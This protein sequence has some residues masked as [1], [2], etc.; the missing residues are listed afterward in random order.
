MKR[1][2]IIG[3]LL[4]VAVAAVGQGV[5][6]GV[7]SDA[8]GAMPLEFVNIGVVGSAKGTATDPSGR[9][10]LTLTTS[11]S[12]TLRFSFTGYETA[13]HR[14]SVRGGRRLRLNV[15]L[16][17]SATQL[18][19]V[20]VSDET[21]RQ[22]AFTHIETEKLDGTVGPT[23]GVEAVIK[24]LP[25][26]HS[27]NELSSQYSVRGGSFDE[28]LVYI[29]GVEIFR[30]MLIRSGQQEGM[31][32]INPDM[33]DYILFSPGGFDA[34][35]GDKLSSVLDITYLRP[36]EFRGK[37]SASLLGANATVQGRA[38]ERM[39]YAV[40]FR[41]HSNQYVL[42]SLDT[43]GSYTTSYTDLQ[44]LLGYHVNDKLDLG[45][46]AV[47]T[48]NVYGLV[49]ESQTT[50]FGGF[51]MPMVLNV[52]FDGQEQDRYNTLLGALS[53]DWRPSEDWR[54]K[55]H[56]SVQHINESERYDVQSQYWLYQLAM[57][58]TAGDTTM[59][60][61]GVGTFLEHARNR[62]TTNIATLSLNANRYAR[63]GCWDMGL[64]LQVEDIGDHLREWKWVDSAGYALPTHIL[65]FGDSSNYPVNPILQLYANSNS[66]MRT[67]RT[68]AYLQR[69]LNFHTTSGADIKLL[70]GLRGQIYH[71]R[72][73]SNGLQSDLG[74]RWM[75]SPRA[76]V[77]LK[78]A[79]KHDL[80][81]RLA[82][83]IYSQAPFYREYRRE[84]GTLL[85]DVRPQHSYQVTGTADWNFR[86]WNKPFTL[87][88]DLYYKYLT[89]LIPYTIDNLRL[90]YMP[91]KTAVG[92]TVGL[93]LRLNAELIKDLESWAS[94]SLMQTQEDIDGDGLGWLARPTDQRLSFKLFLQ[95]NVPDMPWWRMSLTLVYATG[96]PVTVPMLA[97]SEEAFRLPNYYRIDW[98]NTIR[99]S[100]FESLKHK[101]L[102]RLVED[103]QVGIEV[104]N[105][106]NFRNV[107]SYLWV[108]DYENRY[109]PV[110]NYLTARQLNVKLTVLF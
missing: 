22:S 59:F 89:N 25:D 9:Y 52:Y 46:L 107:V 97:R 64:R 29:N 12:V 6:E 81:F 54:I 74:G 5:V 37:V 63:L 20:E 41:Q 11:D 45:L 96:T 102:F 35:Y 50:T 24:M 101:R 2:F 19:E 67:L 68:S 30:P 56:L 106:F 86:L 110:P 18:H 80:L 104:F 39:S 7:V 95:D 26:V 73:E 1:L 93:S 66:S 78:P 55:A 33:V 105:L 91:D 75:L 10:Q 4:L 8:T 90:R 99:L 40:G 53:A 76:S 51:V 16:K 100:Q 58:E 43:K 87:A 42:G 23:G 57:G 49:P 92:Y 32:I 44:A 38:G 79:I 3:A 13:E 77:S 65:P 15:K 17:P 71:S 28:N 72:L 82:A 34:T 36:Q 88:A 69:E 47:W 31:S 84:D 103:I 14:V 60:D 70:A 109:Y 98:G 83:G 108:S 61:R 27:N 62:L 48:R 21:N 94:L 85:P